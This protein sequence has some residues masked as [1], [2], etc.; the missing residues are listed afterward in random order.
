MCVCVLVVCLQVCVCVTL[1]CMCMCSLSPQP[2]VHSGTWRGDSGCQLCQAPVPHSG[3]DRS[4]T[5]DGIQATAL[6]PQDMLD[7]CLL[8]ALLGLLCLS[9]G[10]CGR[11]PH[12]MCHPCA[13]CMRVPKGLEQLLVLALAPQAW[14][15]PCPWIS[16]SSSCAHHPHPFV[17][18]TTLSLAHSQECTKY[19]ASTCQDCIQLGPGCAWCQKP[20]R[21]AQK[22]QELWVPPA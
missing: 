8:L 20:V 9:S 17:L 7:Q 1:W 6:S 5:Q 14:P 21:A 10:E 15:P 11:C 22:C 4:P 2:P 12:H 3:K 13:L 18:P 16:C 19:K